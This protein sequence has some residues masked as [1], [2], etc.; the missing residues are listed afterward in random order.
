MRRMGVMRSGAKNMCS[1][2]T[3]PTPWAPNATARAASS[4]VSALALTFMRRI[5][6][7]QLRNSPSSPE[8]ASGAAI[9]CWPRYTLP[10]EPSMVI[11]SPRRSTVE[12]PWTTAVPADASTRRDPAPATQ[13]LPQLRA[14]TAAWLVMPPRAVRTPL[15]ACMPPMSSGDVSSRTSSTAMPFSV[16][17]SASPAVKAAR[18]EAAPG[19]AA[20]PEAM[21]EA[22]DAAGSLSRACRAWSRCWGVTR[23]A[24]ASSL[25][26]RPS[27]TMSVAIRTAAGPVRLPLRVCSMN[28]RPD[29]MVNSQSWTSRKCFSRR[30]TVAR[31]SAYSSGLRASSSAMGRGEREPLT[32]SSPC[33]L[34]RYSPK[35]MSSPV[36]GLRVKSTPVPE[37]SSRLPYT[38]AIT[39]TAVPRRPVISLIWR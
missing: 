9:G 15:A 2:R 34:N 23:R 26:T 31:S 18:P 28:R 39:L 16:M 36:E 14:T 10:V 22:S 13:G 20:V 6:C 5:A 21:S 12:V 11:Q 8:P 32:T 4:G 25:V 24:T 7:T 19:D 1:V 17:A 3:S 35:S 29:S 33:A 30:F 27:R 38:M 37:S